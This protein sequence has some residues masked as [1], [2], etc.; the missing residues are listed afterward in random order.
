[1]TDYQGSISILT[2]TSRQEALRLRLEEQIYIVIKGVWLV[3]VTVTKATDVTSVV[4]V[5]SGRHVARKLRVRINATA[6]RVIRLRGDCEVV[7]L[8]L[9]TWIC[10]ELDLFHNQY[11]LYIPIWSLAFD[12]L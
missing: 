2:L 10:G 9:S 8:I 3:R 12:R 5:R 4:A 6:K 7:E 11:N 1:M